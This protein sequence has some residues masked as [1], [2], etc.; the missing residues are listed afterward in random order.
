MTGPERIAVL[1]GVVPFM[2][3][4]AGVLVHAGLTGPARRAARE[5]ER[6]LG[7]DAAMAELDSLPELPLSGYSDQAL[8]EELAAS[9]AELERWTAWVRAE[10]RDEAAKARIRALLPRHNE[11]RDEANRRLI[12]ETMRLRAKLDALPPGPHDDVTEI[13]QFGGGVVHRH[14]ERCTCG[15]CKREWRLSEGRDT[16]AGPGQGRPSE[17]PEEP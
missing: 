9:N 4:I 1:F 7:W 12:A 2:L 8:H 6:P 15:V 3:L 11:L 13:H 16:L 14:V 10:P 17:T 5:P